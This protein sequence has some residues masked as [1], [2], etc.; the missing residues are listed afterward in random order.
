MLELVRQAMIQDSP[1]TEMLHH[2]WGGAHPHFCQAAE[3]R[4]GLHL[5]HEKAKDCRS[6]SAANIFCITQAL[7]DLIC[8]WAGSDHEL[9]WAHA[10][11]AATDK[12]IPALPSPLLIPVIIL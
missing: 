12:A 4:A 3:G 6:G 11:I 7:E 1:A 9:T 8:P 10:G 5:K 2:S